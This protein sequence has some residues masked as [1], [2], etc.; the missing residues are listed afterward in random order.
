[1]IPLC[2]QTSRSACCTRT[3]RALENA[4]ATSSIAVRRRSSSIVIE[5]AHDNVSGGKREAQPHSITLVH[6]VRDPRQDRVVR[7]TVRIE[8]LPDKMEPG[9]VAG[10]RGQRPVVGQPDLIPIT[11]IG[12]AVQKIRW[13]EAGRIGLRNSGHVETKRTEVLG[14]DEGYLLIICGFAGCRWEGR[15]CAESRAETG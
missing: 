10:P 6:S 11:A 1:M 15:V 8:H 4:P 7:R 13:T 5:S 3:G 14:K 12:E 2:H 9:H